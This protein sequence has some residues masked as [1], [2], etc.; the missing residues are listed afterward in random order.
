MSVVATTWEGLGRGHGHLRARR[1]TVE[2][3]GRRGF[4]RPR[5]AELWLPGPGGALAEAPPLAALADLT[6]A[7]SLRAH[8]LGARERARVPSP[9]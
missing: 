7:R 4:A 3:G 9:W 6:E 2:A 8:R 5:R 1:A